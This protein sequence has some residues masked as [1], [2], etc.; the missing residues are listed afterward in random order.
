[1]IISSLVTFIVY[2]CNFARYIVYSGVDENRDSL[3]KTKP[4]ESFEI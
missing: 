2:N 1:M 4:K 3:H